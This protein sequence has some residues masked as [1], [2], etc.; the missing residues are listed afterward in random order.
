M[1]NHH[2]PMTTKFFLIPSIRIIQWCCGNDLSNIFDPS[3]ELSNEASCSLSSDRVN[4]QLVE[5]EREGATAVIWQLHFISLLH[6]FLFCECSRYFMNF[7]NLQFWIYIS[8]DRVNHSFTFR[9]DGQ[10]QCNAKNI[11][12]LH[13]FLFWEYFQEHFVLH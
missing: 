8:S 4:Q 12:L 2:A 9:K 7:N 13:H 11:S 5:R 1:M 3:L 6:C 10:N